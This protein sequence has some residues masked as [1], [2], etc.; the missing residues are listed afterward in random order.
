VTQMF[1]FAFIPRVMA[2]NTAFVGLLYLCYLSPLFTPAADLARVQLS[3]PLH[4][5]L[6]LV[7]FHSLRRGLYGEHSPSAGEE[8]GPDGRYS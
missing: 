6:L 4:T 5:L 2:F 3:V 1:P 7:V 8:K